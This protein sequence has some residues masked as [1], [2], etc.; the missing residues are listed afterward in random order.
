[1]KLGLQFFNMC[2][3]MCAVSLGLV[4][5]CQTDRAPDLKIH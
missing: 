5:A 1:M 2:M 4:W 3:R